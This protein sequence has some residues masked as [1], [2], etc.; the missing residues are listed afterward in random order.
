MQNKEPNQSA[1]TPKSLIQIDA[2]MLYDQLSA[3]L[4][5]LD[6]IKY[7]LSWSV[8]TERLVNSIMQNCHDILTSTPK[9]EHYLKEFENIL[10]QFLGHSEPLLKIN[11]NCKDLSDGG[12]DPETETDLFRSLCKKLL[13]FLD[14]LRKLEAEIS[15]TQ[16]YSSAIPV[17]FEHHLKSE[18]AQSVEAMKLRVRK[19]Y[20][21]TN[22]GKDLYMIEVSGLAWRM[23]AFFRSLNPTPESLMPLILRNLNGLMELTKKHPVLDAKTELSTILAVEEATD[24]LQV[25]FELVSNDSEL[26]LL[27][28]S[29]VDEGVR[30]IHSKHQGVTEI[31]IDGTRYSLSKSKRRSEISSSS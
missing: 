12:I 1:K 8:G 16:E 25:L 31:V 7:W 17:G 14:D 11:R 18:L 29:N 6:T 19:L 13:V 28:F 15:T 23:Y 4:R 21:R 2:S 3:V 30:I 27:P 24:S 9:C 22:E 20:K 5:Y 26:A 10:L